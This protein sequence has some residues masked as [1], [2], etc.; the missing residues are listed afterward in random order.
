MG[1]DQGGVDAPGD[2]RFERGIGCRLAETVEP[3]AFQVRNP[4][5]KLEPQQA[6]KGANMIGIAA[7]IGVAAPGRD[8][9]LVIA[10]RRA[11]VRL[12]WQSPRS[13]WCG[14]ERSGR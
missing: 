3:P 9:A 13:P 8:R 10:A 1:A 2:Q 12:R 4:R 14:T 6:A 11:R 7:A 5:R